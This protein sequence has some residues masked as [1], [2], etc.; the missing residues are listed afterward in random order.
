LDINEMYMIAL[1][2]D[3]DDEEALFQALAER[4]RLFAEQRLE[5]P[6]ACEDVVQESLATIAEKYRCMEFSSSFA[7]WVYGV[8]QKKIQR[9]YRAKRYYMDRFENSPAQGVSR[10]DPELQIALLACLRE[11][12][13]RSTSQARVLN[14]VFQGYTI[15]EI[16][17][18]LGLTPNACYVQLSRARAHIRDCLERKKASL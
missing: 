14:L 7:A 1:S 11:L 12:C 16:C 13:R 18:R 17:A 3:R 8:L 10:P 2:G 4:F 6:A 9:Y 5:D 15:S